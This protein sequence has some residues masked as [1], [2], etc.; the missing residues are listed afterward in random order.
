MSKTSKMEAA[1][2]QLPRT[3][4]ELLDFFLDRESIEGFRGFSAN[5][6]AIKNGIE[7]VTD[8]LRADEK[9]TVFLPLVAGAEGRKVYKEDMTEPHFELFEVTYALTGAT[10]RVS[11]IDDNNPVGRAWW[12]GNYYDHASR[13]SLSMNFIEI[14]DRDEGGDYVKW[15]LVT[16]VPEDLVDRAEHIGPQDAREMIIAVKSDIAHI[17]EYDWAAEAA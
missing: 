2:Q 6:L 14:H 8:L 11:E 1:S 7:E 12:Q 16:D 5:A 15:Q 10:L 9:G 3:T 13:R 4:E 17:E